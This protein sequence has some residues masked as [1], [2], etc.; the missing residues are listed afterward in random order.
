MGAATDPR[1]A[2]AAGP[3]L[4]RC[5]RC[6]RPLHDPAARA[7]EIG[8]ECAEAEFRARLGGIEQEP[9]PGL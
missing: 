7:R 5:R 9:L 6:R 3:R 2:P 8:D 4:V 1:T